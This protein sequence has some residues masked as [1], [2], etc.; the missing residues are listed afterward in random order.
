MHTSIHNEPLSKKP[1]VVLP[2][3]TAAMIAKP[4]IKD[5]AKK[6][7]YTTTFLNPN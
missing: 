3:Q 5:E 6:P 2:I 4:P 7:E 1:E